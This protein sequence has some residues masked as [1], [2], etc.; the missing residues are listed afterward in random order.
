[1]DLDDVLADFI[2]TFMRFGN[3]LYG[4]DEKARPT[5]WEWDGVPFPEGVEK[6]QFIRGVWK[7]ITS[8]T[9][10]WFREIDKIEVVAPSLIFELDKKT[11]LYFPT[12]R[13]QTK[14]YSTRKQ[15]T[16][17]VNEIF[18]IAWPSVIV[19]DAKGEMAKALKYDYFIDDRPKNCIEVKEALPDCKVF[20]CDSNHNRTFH[21]ARFPR[22][23]NANEFAQIVLSS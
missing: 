3:E 1:M 17:W 4:V 10:F 15:S 12:A 22:V 23:N 13:T 19:S 18:G 7:R 8:T 5:S 11:E 9:D 16:A 14:G 2:K 20:L 6:Q 21:D